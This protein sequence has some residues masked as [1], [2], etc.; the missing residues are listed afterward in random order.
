MNRIDKMI[1]F[2][3][4][5]L[6]ALILISCKNGTNH[7]VEPDNPNQYRPKSWFEQEHADR[8]PLRWQLKGS[9]EIH[10]SGTYEFHINQ[11]GED[12]TF[13]FLD[14]NLSSFWL[15]LDGVFYD[16][17]NAVDE[18]MYGFT[19]GFDLPNISVHFAPNPN[20]DEREIITF[21]RTLND[22]YVKF[23]FKQPASE[24]V[25]YIDSEEIV[26][27]STDRTFVY[28]RYT[29][30]YNTICN[31]NGDT[32]SIKCLSDNTIDIVSFNID[33]VS[34]E[35][36]NA[37]NASL[38][39]AHIFVDDNILTFNIPENTSG[40][41]LN[42]SVT[43]ANGEKTSTFNICQPSDSKIDS[44][45]CELRTP[46]WKVTCDG[47]E[48]YDTD[49]AFKV[50]NISNKILLESINF[51]KWECIEIWIDG[52]KENITY[53]TKSIRNMLNMDKLDSKLKLSF[54]SNY[55]LYERVVELRLK[56][57]NPYLSSRNYCEYSTLVF[58]QAP[59]DVD[60]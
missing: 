51:N 49:N 17:T 58:V 32:F 4:V 23:I 28:N 7:I 52:T 55:S 18:L 45:F 8:W 16:K 38:K 36:N 14:E 20:M 41:K 30:Q 13:T 39:N 22:K 3:S 54:F 44:E 9:D 6:S 50:P 19:I 46:Q 34:A 59:R 42:Y 56:C 10:D 29:K 60:W 57:K 48:L 37:K 43:V 24:S 47:M 1:S 26:W 25:K 11:D 31:S 40:K 21:F 5:L 33:D 27:K 12:I 15:S 2:V 35:I 53:G